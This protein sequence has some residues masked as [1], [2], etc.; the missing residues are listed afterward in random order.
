MS[1]LN[2][3]FDLSELPE[4]RNDFEPIPPGWYDAH[5]TN[6]EIKNTKQ[7]DGQYISVRFDIT[8]PAHQGRCVFNNLNIK[9]QSLKAEEIG[10]QQLGELMRAIGLS[11][12]TDTDQLIGGSVK[13]R[14]DIEHSE[15]YGDSNRIKAYKSGNDLPFAKSNFADEVAKV[16]ARVT[17]S[18][19]KST[20]PWAKK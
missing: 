13:I 16:E 18:S 12:I 6:A 10:R 15:V 9:N 11:K 14:I 8:G 7:G 19:K 20:P 4:S 1:R 3:S 2:E 17:E 5:I